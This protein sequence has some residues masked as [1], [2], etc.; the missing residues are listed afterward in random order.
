MA[1][2]RSHRPIKKYEVK[3]LTAIQIIRQIIDLITDRFLVSF[4]FLFESKPINKASKKTGKK[5]KKKNK[6]IV[7]DP[8]TL[9]FKS[10]SFENISLQ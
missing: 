7:N 9:F 6:K 1:I 3:M 8:K 10:N 5:N 4:I 2:A